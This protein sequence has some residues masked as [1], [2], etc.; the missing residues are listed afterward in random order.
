MKNP[1]TTHDVIIIGGGAAGML[2]GITCAQQGKS[3]LI[4]DK[5]ERLGRKLLITGKGRCNITNNCQRDELFKNIPHN[6]KFLYS[7]FSQFT[8]QDA[9]DFFESLG[10]ATKTERGNRV[11][12]VSDKAV[13]VVDALVKTLN[14]Y[15]VKTVR[16]K[17]EGL[18]LEDGQIKGVLCADNIIY[19]AK[20]VIIA[21]GGRSYPL[22]GSTGD[23]YAL[24]M[25]AGHTVSDVSPSLVPIVTQEKWCADAMGLSLKNVTLKVIDNS[26]NKRIVFEEL[27]EML[28]THFGV[29]GP[30]VLSASA[31]MEE[32]ESNRYS[33]EI[34]LKPAL[35]EQTLDKRLLREIATYSNRDFSNLLGSL[36]PQKLIAVVVGLSGINGDT[37]ANSITREQRATLCKLLKSLP[38][39]VKAFRPIE[40][41]IVTR[42]GVSTVEID[43]KTMESKLT[44]GLF[45]AGEVIDVDAYTG[46]FN[47]QIAFSTGFLAGLHA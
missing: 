1:I 25:Q 11:F 22:T 10:V 41:A 6:P 24:A 32:L 27:G 5:N 15:G 20:S 42:G 34:D 12:P 18:K 14:K 47:L 7:A 26:K 39:T 31:H 30:L 37:K 46:G 33:L 35:D 44:K 2:A 36:L 17:A 45:F 8:P 21:T 23:G 29:S 43:P 13:E 40:E 28:F 9:I 19:N 16:A 4:L 3:V 38:L